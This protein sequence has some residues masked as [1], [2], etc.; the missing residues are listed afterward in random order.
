MDGK[1]EEFVESTSI[2]PSLIFNFD[3]TVFYSGKK[4]LKVLI[5]T[6]CKKSIEKIMTKQQHIT[7][8]L[9]IATDDTYVK[10]LCI[11]PL[12]NAQYSLF[13]LYTFLSSL[14]RRMVG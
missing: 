5:K 7:F 8:R 4:S 1:V 3:E 9:C 13:L 11:F 2:S 10:P 12:K 6:G 14:D